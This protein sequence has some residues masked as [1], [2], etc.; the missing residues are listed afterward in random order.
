MLITLCYIPVD[1]SRPSQD[2]LVRE[3]QETGQTITRL[4]T[5]IQ[6]MRQKVRHALVS[7]A[8]ILMRSG[9]G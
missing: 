7:P 2:V 4:E 3:L 5:E 1:T 6:E 9:T 8:V